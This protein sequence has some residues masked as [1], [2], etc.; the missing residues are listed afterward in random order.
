MKWNE[1]GAKCPG[2]G[3]MCIFG[4]GL[5]ATDLIDKFNCY[6]IQEDKR[7]VLGN[8]DEWKQ[9]EIGFWKKKSNN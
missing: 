8:V 5:I 7:K 6:I 3:R 9:V 2:C 4:E 1:V